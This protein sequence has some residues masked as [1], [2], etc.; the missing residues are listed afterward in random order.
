MRGFLRETYSYAIL[1]V[2]LFAIASIAVWQTLTYLGEHL[3]PDNYQI[4]A[5]LIWT[6]TL[7]FMLIAG[8]FGLWAVQ[9]SAQAES[10][11]RIGRIV[12]GMDYL[13]DGLLSVDRRGR[14]NGS[15]PAARD[16][17]GD[18]FATPIP[19]RKVFPCLSA[20][21]ETLLLSSRAPTE[22]ERV[23]TSHGEARMLRYRSQP[24]E[25]MTLVLL[26]DVTAMTAQ[27]RHNR[28]V[29]RLQL[30]GQIARGVAHDFNNI[31]CA[32]SGHAS[33][34][35][36]L[37]PGSPDMNASIRTIAQSVERG[38]AL[39]THL[40][41][42]ARPSAATENAGLDHDWLHLAA[43]T[44]RN[45]LPAHWHVELR[46]ERLP[47]VSL[48]SLQMEQLILNIGLQIA[49]VSREPG[50]LRVFAAPPSSRVHLYDVE[51]LYAVVVL[52]SRTDLGQLIE[53]NADFVIK[54]LGD[55]GVILSLIRTMVE[56]AGGALQYLLPPGI[57]PIYRILL[58]KG[59]V[60]PV[61]P[62]D[63][64]RKGPLAELGALVAGWSILSGSGGS[65]YL[66]HE[67]KLESLGVR[68]HRADSVPAI[69]REISD[70]TQFDAA[71]LDKTLLTKEGQG[72]LRA[73]QRLAPTTGIVVLGEEAPASRDPA[74]GVVFLQENPDLQ[75][76][77][78]AL[79]EARSQAA[80]RRGQ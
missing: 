17:A 43:E 38:S 4:V 41:E 21:D 14:I 34:L 47:P 58:P 48:S 42:L 54:P 66:S 26:S 5:I 3:P 71:L 62:L 50:T 69:L 33:L 80:K 22:L 46:T 52:I 59:E 63:T 8:A 29:A 79:V 24:L 10:R 51:D 2:V 36:R 45:S 6:Q 56:E 65:K 76:L 35:Q 64:S 77:L 40:L 28:H 53:S 7:G 49:E 44:L 55:A 13:H 78:V 25:G 12:D 27:R 18:A 37:P 11:R 19:I 39:A 67:Q 30:I 16:L 75:S 9:F 72:V 20:D 60:L 31:L 1:L 73:I 70:T 61:S 15:N 32:I 57:E 74:A 23:F 68:L